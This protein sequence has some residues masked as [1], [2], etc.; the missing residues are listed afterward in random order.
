MPPC[1]QLHRCAPDAGCCYD[2]AE[3]CAPV[4]GKYV[5][6]PFLVSFT[7][8]INDWLVYIIVHKTHI[9][10]TEIWWHTGRVLSVYVI[11]CRR[12]FK[13]KFIKNYTRMD[14]TEQMKIV[15]IVTRH[16]FH[17]G[18]NYSNFINFKYH[19]FFSAKSVYI[20]RY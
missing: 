8:F 13:N 19:I 7:T 16:T 2:E 10:V 11:K 6:I 1:V 5:A 17:S 14:M 20:K 3:V 15:I 9:E 12:C 18:M 4:D